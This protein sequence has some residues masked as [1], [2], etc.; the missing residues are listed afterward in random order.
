MVIKSFIL[1]EIDTK[2]GI[3]G[4]VNYDNFFDNVL[5]ETLG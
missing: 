4:K 3:D 5:S 2:F 1:T